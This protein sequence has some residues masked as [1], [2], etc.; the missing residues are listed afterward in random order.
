MNQINKANALRSFHIKRNPLILFNIWDT[1][2]ARAMQHAGVKVIATSSWSVAAAHGVDDGE[3]LPFDLV[4]ANAHRIATNIDLPLTID[5]EGGYSH[6]LEQLRKNIADVIETGAV[7]INFEDQ[8]IGG[9]GL[10]SVSDQCDR[11]NA[12]RQTADQKAV[13][14]FINARTDIFLKV[15]TIN[16]NEFHLEEAIT[17]SK[18]YADAGADGF[19]APG[20]TDAKHIKKLCEQ[21]PIPVNI[22]VLSDTPSLKEL[23]ELGVARISYGPYPYCQMIDI[24]T[25]VVTD[26]ST[27]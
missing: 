3:K 20:L 27:F 6:S 1:G 8:I 7:G 11:I 26:L 9:N 16:H 17:R 23:S 24:L 13:P 10:F 14:V 15:D 12:I 21:S 19:F 25:K 4:M 5:L 18:A 2:S 22:M